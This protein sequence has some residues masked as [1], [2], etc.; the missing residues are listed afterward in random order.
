MSTEAP[1]EP[2]VVLLPAFSDEELAILAPP[3][4]IVVAP[5]LARVNAADR[6]GVL[7]TA[8][9]GLVARGVLE[10]PSS[11]AVATAETFDDLATVEVSVRQ[12]VHALVT[13]RAAAQAVVAVS[14]TTTEGRDYW[15]AHVVDEVVVVEQVDANGLH[16]FLLSDVP[17]LIGAVLDA[18]VH[19]ATIDGAGGPLE[20]SA[21]EIAKPT[22]VLKLLG[23]SFVCADVIV[24]CPADTEV[25]LLGVFT[26]PGGAWVVRSTYG[27]GE[28]VVATPR[29]TGA[30]RTEVAQQVAAALNRRVRS[31]TERRVSDAGGG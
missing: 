1:A 12:D 19:P 8:F 4:G 22:A 30:L 24:R 10:M 29:T 31:D 25:E 27:S 14:R 18:V 2:A 26:G 15:Y 7:R 11:K 28:P 6:P 9:R 3:G 16:Q 5:F 13:L 20:L 23:D 17:S 21:A